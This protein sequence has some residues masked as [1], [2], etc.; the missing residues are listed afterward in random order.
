MKNFNPMQMMGGFQMNPMQMMMQGFGVPNKPSINKQQ[1]QQFLPNMNENIFEQ[2]KK[3][4]RENGISEEEI[5]SGMK[6][7]REL[8]NKR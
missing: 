8:T 6:F 3:Q 2:L 5:E 1:F 4:A 7:I